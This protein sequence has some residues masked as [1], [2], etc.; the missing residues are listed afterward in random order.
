MINWLKS[1]FTT[2]SKP[3]LKR[4]ITSGWFPYTGAY[5]AH[6]WVNGDHHFVIYDRDEGFRSTLKGE[7]FP[8][9]KWF[10]KRMIN[11]QSAYMS[12]WENE[13]GGITVLV[14]TP[15]IE[16]ITSTHNLAVF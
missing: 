10:T 1:L 16:H 15:V 6:L 5:K 13:D 4:V 9:V 2:P 8:C 14:D 12:A 7:E 11:P 3:R